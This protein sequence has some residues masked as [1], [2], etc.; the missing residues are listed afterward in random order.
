MIEHRTAPQAVGHGLGICTW[1]IRILTLQ[2]YGSRGPGRG[3]S[4]FQAAAVA[5][6][7][8]SEGRYARWD[9]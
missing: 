6:W 1:L 2:L 9:L 5:D 4:G 7:R 8:G 3:H